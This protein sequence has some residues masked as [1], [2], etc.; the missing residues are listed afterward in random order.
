MKKSTQKGAFVDALA[1]KS[2]CAINPK[3]IKIEI[4]PKSAR[5]QLFSI[6]C[7]LLTTFAQYLDHFIVSFH[8][9]RHIYVIWG[10]PYGVAVVY[11]GENM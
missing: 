6:L 2:S 1:F 3:E 8:W 4:A 7:P 9:T 5:D 11:R 10:T